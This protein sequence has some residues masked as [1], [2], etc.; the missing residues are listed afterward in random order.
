MYINGDG[1]KG[2]HLN[3]GTKQYH[4][5]LFENKQEL[6]PYLAPFTKS[7][8]P[9]YGYN[10]P[11]LHFYGVNVD[12]EDLKQLPIN[13]TRSYLYG[14]ICGLIATDGNVA[15]GNTTIFQSD[16]EEMSE[17]HRI[18]FEVGMSPG[19]VDIYRTDSPYTGEYAPS[20]VLRIKACSLSINDILR[21]DHRKQFNQAD[22]RSQSIFAVSVE[23]T[24]EETE[25]FCA[26]E[27][28]SNT[29]T[30]EGNILTGNCF[31]Q[32]ISDSIQ[33]YDK[34]GYP[35]IY[36]ALKEAAETMRRGGGVGYDF[37]RIRPKNAEVKGT[38]SFASGPCSYINVF[39]VSCE[40]VES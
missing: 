7:S 35:G 22:K 36:I 37:S 32:P 5:H 29:F 3:D 19:T 20:Y 26:V 27:P 39:D 6:A 24:E 30:I 31:V 10:K 34:E 18:L 40:T 1:S 33:D 11:S 12:N 13:K 21:S 17:I 16:Y 2:R 9:Y 25:V 28:I 38:A 15:K 4:I 8:K 23:E 14:F